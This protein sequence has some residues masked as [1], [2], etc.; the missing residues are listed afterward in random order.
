GWADPLVID[1][2]R[3]LQLDDLLAEEVRTELEARRNNR[4]ALL[5]VVAV[6][7]D[8]RDADAHAEPRERP[9]EQVEAD[10]VLEVA[11]GSA[12]WG[13]L[14]L[15][16]RAADHGVRKVRSDFVHHEVDLADEVRALAPPVRTQADLLDAVLQLGDDG[17]DL[18]PLRAGEV[19]VLQTVA[20]LAAAHG[21]DDL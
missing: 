2:A 9:T 14:V 5:G 8:V 3:V 4:E 11:V 16:H 12:E 18:T 17:E 19:D 1:V 20:E 21:V 13:A 10:L 7:A 15:R 6:G